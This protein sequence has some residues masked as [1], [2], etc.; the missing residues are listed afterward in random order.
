MGTIKCCSSCTKRQAGCH[1]DCGDYIV[2][3][4]FYEVEKAEKHEKMMVQR[5]LDD[6]TIHSITKC[7]KYIGRAK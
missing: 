6:Q 7:K 5:R 4:A 2:E 1:A 3:K